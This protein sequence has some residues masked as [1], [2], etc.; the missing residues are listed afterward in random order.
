[1]QLSDKLLSLYL[2][3]LLELLAKDVYLVGQLFIEIQHVV[4]ILMVFL[5][6][7]DH[8]L[9]LDGHYLMSILF[10]ITPLDTENVALLAEA[11]DDVI[12]LHCK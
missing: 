4:L 10:F 5:L 3:S 2:L 8:L 11:E 7:F 6:I 12:E 9:P 1:M